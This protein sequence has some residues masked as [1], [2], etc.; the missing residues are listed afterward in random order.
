M[1]LRYTPSIERCLQLFETMSHQ[2]S[3]LPAYS[4]WYVSFFSKSPLQDSEEHAD[5]HRG[6][7]GGLDPPHCRTS[8]RQHTTAIN[9][10]APEIFTSNRLILVGSLLSAQ[11]GYSILRSMRLITRTMHGTDWDA[12]IDWA[13]FLAGRKLD[14]QKSCLQLTLLVKAPPK[15]GLEYEVDPKP[16]TTI[17]R[18]R[19]RFQE[20]RSGQI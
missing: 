5:G 10:S 3:P 20:I 9:D 16:L 13:K 15:I 17:A 2:I 11:S 1:R 8:S 19:G 6:F 4:W 7:Q 14:K 18:Y 12:N